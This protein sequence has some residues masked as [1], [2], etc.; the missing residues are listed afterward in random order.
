MSGIE[1]AIRHVGSARRMAAQ[2][3][4]AASTV[5][6]WHQTGVVSMTHAAAVSRLTGVPV[7]E[8][9]P[10]QRPSTRILRLL[11][12][13][14]DATIA[15]LRAALRM[16]EQTIR[17]AVARLVDC[18]LLTKLEFVEREGVC[19]P[20]FCYCLAQEGDKNTNGR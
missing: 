2:L 12:K 4:I 20:Q 3:G 7:M 15:E 13:R 9:L 10:S 16:P 11:A 8:L 1:A 17:K 6:H 19:E 5:N 18:G 14:E